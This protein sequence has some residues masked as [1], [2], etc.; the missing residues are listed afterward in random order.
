MTL[1]S[2]YLW[3]SSAANSYIQPNFVLHRLQ[4]TSRTQCRPVSMILSAGSLKLQIYSKMHGG[5]RDKKKIPNLEGYLLLLLA[6]TALINSS[7]KPRWSTGDRQWLEDFRVFIE[8]WS[9]VLKGERKLSNKF[10]I[11]CV[12]I[13]IKKSYLVVFNA[14]Q[15][16]F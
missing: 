15:K 2:L 13:T 5:M 6:S 10:E 3:S 16:G 8:W 11:F 7:K 14:N 4:E 1:A 9:R 12:H